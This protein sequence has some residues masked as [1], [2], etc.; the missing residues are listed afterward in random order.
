[1]EI[2]KVLPVGVLALA[3]GL[4]AAVLADTDAP[5]EP[6]Q[7]FFD[8]NCNSGNTVPSLEFDVIGSAMFSGD[9]EIMLGVDSDVK[10]KDGSYTFGGNFTVSGSSDN[11]Q[12]SQYQL[13]KIDELTAIDLTMTGMKQVKCDKST[14]TLAGSANLQSSD[15]VLF[16]ICEVQA[17]GGITVDSDPN[18]GQVKVVE[19]ILN[20]GTGDLTFSNASYC[21]IE[22]SELSFG[23]YDLSG[24]AYCVIKDTTVDGT[25]ID[26]REDCNL[27]PLM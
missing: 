25:P 12:G 11:D 27:D 13:Q 17:V 6:A 19:S 4:P 22:K 20:A 9:C 8:N 3:M 7:P 26:D 21:L 5:P 16:D 18:Y 1:M 2:K 15:E 23:G 10:S 14:L 24:C